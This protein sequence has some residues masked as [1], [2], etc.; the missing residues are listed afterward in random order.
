MINVNVKGMAG[1]LAYLKL[2]GKNT[3]V[4][5]KKGIAKATVFLQGEVK[6]SIAGYRSEHISVDTGRFLNSVE[7]QID[8]LTGKV[9]SKVPY[10]RKLEFG[11]GFTA[12]P[13]K[14]FTNSA[15]RSKP[16]ITELIKQEVQ[17]I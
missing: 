11:T 9:F 1:T 4:Q 2:K 7:F 16:K 17:Y 10:A 12:S 13:R 3:E 15:D 6:Q 8:K 14:H 5:A